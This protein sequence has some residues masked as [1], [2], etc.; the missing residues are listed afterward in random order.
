VQVVSVTLRDFRSYEHVTAA[1][2]G[3]LTVVTGRNG[4]G[5]T[6]LLEGLYFGCTGLSF[7]TTSDRELVRFG[8]DTARV[9]VRANDDTGGHDLAVGFSPGQ[10]KRMSVD[11]SQVP[12]LLDAPERPLLSVFL[13]DRLD[14]VKGVPALRRAH[15]DRFVAAL[16]PARTATRR[17]YAQALA[18]RNSLLMRIRAGRQAPESLD[19][20]DG[21]LAV[22]GMQLI[23]DRAA[24]A[25]RVAD[26]FSRLAS[27]IGLDGPASIAYRPRSRAADAAELAG[28]LGARRQ[29]DLARGF[30]THGPHRDDLAI[31]L[32]G[33]ELRAYGSQGQQRLV[34]LAL[35][36][37]EREVLAEARPRPPVMLLD[38]VMSELDGV[39]RGALVE[40]LRSTPGQAVITTTDLE[41]VPRA[42]ASETTRL[43]VREGRVLAEAAAA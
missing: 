20:W 12:R 17:A 27:E 43:A 25:D 18:Q 28:E 26:H 34:L 22:A 4:A 15:L 23:A 7:R 42:H 2:G 3:E 10:P 36:I 13:P 16:W 8:A 24:A 40:L 11:G 21:Q 39:R 6:N 37:A 19:A 38:D 33:R 14:L 32:A 35:L 1:F 29:A 30:T 31:L 41:H 9:V 5:K